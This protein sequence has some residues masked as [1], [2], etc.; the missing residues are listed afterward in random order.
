MAPVVWLWRW[1]TNVNYRR[2]IYKTRCLREIF[3]DIKA[4]MPAEKQYENRQI[5]RGI[6]EH[7][8]VLEYVLDDEQHRI[9][10]EKMTEAEF[11][12]SILNIERV[13]GMSERN[14]VNFC[15]AFGV[16]YRIDL[17][18]LMN[19]F[20]DILLKTSTGNT[21]AVRTLKDKIWD[22]ISDYAKQE[23]M[24]RATSG[25]EE[26]AK[27]LVFEYLKALIRDT[28]RHPYSGRMPT[29]NEPD[30]LPN[31][32]DSEIILK[33][34]GSTGR[35]MLKKKGVVI[36]MSPAQEAPAEVRET[37]GRFYL[38]VNPNLLTGPPRQL[39]IIFE[40]HELFHI[41]YPEKNE[42]EIRKLTIQY[43]LDHN[44]LE[45]HIK[46][47]KNNKIG[48]VSRQPWLSLLLVQ[49]RTNRSVIY[50][51]YGRSL[52]QKILNEFEISRRMMRDFYI[53]IY[54]E[55][56]AIKLKKI[57]RELEN[58]IYSPLTDGVKAV[59]DKLDAGKIEP[60]IGVRLSRHDGVI[61]GKEIQR[62]K[63]IA[64]FPMKG[65]PW[66]I[67]H[68]FII[69]KVIVKMK[70]D[71][72]VVFIDNSDPIR[73]PGLR[74]LAIREAL[75]RV[76]LKIL[77]PL[78]EYTPI[79]REEAE[80][81]D[82]DGE[83]V[84]FHLMELNRDDDIQWYY[85]VGSDH[86]YWLKKDKKTGLE[87]PDTVLKLVTKQKNNL[88]GYGESGRKS[89]L[90]GV[91][92]IERKGEVL[93]KAEISLLEEKSGF[94]I[95]KIIQPMD[96][97]STKVRDLGHYW[98]LLWD[99]YR[100][101]HAFKIWGFETQEIEE[102]QSKLV[103]ALIGMT[104]EAVA[105]DTIE[106]R[107][108]A[109]NRIKKMLLRASGLGLD[110]YD[111]L[112]MLLLRASKGAK[113]VNDIREGTQEE[114]YKEWLIAILE[115]GKDNELNI[116]H[117][118][119]LIRQM[120]FERAQ[121]I[122]TNEL[123]PLPLRD[124]EREKSSRMLSAG[125]C[126]IDNPLKKHNYPLSITRE[127]QNRIL[128]Q[129]PQGLFSMLGAKLIDD[130]YQIVEISGNPPPGYK[131]A[132]ER[133]LNKLLKLVKAY[134]Q[135]AP[136][137]ITFIFTT[138]TKLTQGQI[139]ACVISSK[140][141]FIYPY[142]FNLSAAKQTEILYH[143]LISHIAKGITDETEAM[144]DTEEFVAN[145]SALTQKE[146]TRRKHVNELKT[147][148]VKPH[149][150][151]PDLGRNLDIPGEPLDEVIDELIRRQ[152]GSG[153]GFSDYWD[154]NITVRDVLKKYIERWPG[155]EEK[156][157]KICELLQKEESPANKMVEWKKLDSIFKV[158]KILWR[159]L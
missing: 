36:I 151:Y 61:S 108:E 22:K 11:L 35:A 141:V 113:V 58:K 57:I 45:K 21:K 87:S 51:G 39:K 128:K 69:L 123:E 137:E 89:R 149:C 12:M 30:R 131:E 8:D 114:R 15:T 63:R 53:P 116:Y 41:L 94:A 27:D 9:I 7:L 70:I 102:E 139:S 90:A 91:I 19:G 14:G 136:P 32:K 67:G 119:Q 48:L 50:N 4:G 147:D 1:R 98:T 16:N 124:K 111:R 74:T 24:Q 153:F 44:L 42:K 72:V 33:A 66:H 86:R 156:K 93:S 88:C 46:F 56:D 49:D 154:E 150:L 40:G 60:G 158:A 122:V 96:T 38:Y 138:E 132:L 104:V 65:D 106:E 5:I 85:V 71:K 75:T 68:I 143:E 159:P 79:A 2:K 84:L 103:E 144:K 47:L 23:I 37:G 59:S 28:K 18:E 20:R 25:R 105:V 26:E 92:F 3:N 127:F 112:L 83:T 43:L 110:K 117:T 118:T 82:K 155:D 152:A 95:K 145:L 34:F 73:K 99:T 31:L 78:V 97:S 134:N 54:C 76:I 10:D 121:D 135:N 125:M 62:P 13:F 107:Q 52:T 148:G 140:L 142:F 130:S 80:L 64:F 133:K 6:E 17:P 100:I 129:H 81:F 157:A 126:V 29:T 55:G 120:L 109:L 146:K 115:A 77:T 101:A